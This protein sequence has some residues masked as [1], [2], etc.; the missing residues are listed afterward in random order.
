MKPARDRF[1]P[2]RKPDIVEMCVANGRLNAAARRSFREFCRILESVLHISDALAK[3]EC[4]GLVGSGEGRLRCKNLDT[5]KVTL[6][7]T[8]DDYFGYASARV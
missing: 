3:L 5:A 6:D 4:L 8:W 2:F 1:I 7:R